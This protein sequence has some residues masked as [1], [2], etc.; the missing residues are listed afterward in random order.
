VTERCPR[1]GKRLDHDGRCAHCGR[2]FPP[3]PAGTPMTRQEVRELVRRVRTNPLSPKCRGRL[4][5]QCAMSTCGCACHVRTWDGHPPSRLCAS[6]RNHGP[7]HWTGQTTE[8]SLLCPGYSD[9]GA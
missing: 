5:K 4:H 8:E 3:A 2:T 1:D 7:H 9:R 6:R